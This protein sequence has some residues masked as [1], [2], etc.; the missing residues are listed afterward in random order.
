[1]PGIAKTL[2]TEDSDKSMR[3]NKMLG[4]RREYPLE[5]DKIATLSTIKVKKDLPDPSE[6]ISCIPLEDSK[7][8][9]IP[10]KTTSRLSGHREL[11]RATSQCRTMVPP[12][13]Q[14]GAET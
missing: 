12:M 4:H 10:S 2:S 1:M 5:R 14:R 9:H 11:E 7:A 6:T 3:P 13:L 8:T